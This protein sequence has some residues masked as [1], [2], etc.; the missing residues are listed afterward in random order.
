VSETIRVL[1]ADDHAIVR[2]GVS[3]LLDAEADIEVVAECTTGAEAVDAARR[4]RP[5]LVLMDIGM[6]G[7]NGIA[8]TRRIKERCPE[9][10]VLVLTVHRSDEYFFEMLEA[11]ASGYVLKAAE[12]DELI[13]AVRAIARG[14]VFLYPSM[15]GRLLQH[16]LDHVGADHQ[17]GP[18]TR[19]ERQVLKLIAQG[20]TTTEIAEKLVVSPSTVYSHRTNLMH[21][22]GLS[23]RHE[24]VR[25][26]RD[27]GLI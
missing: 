15:A 12:T 11:G 21:K 26:A 6:P 2:S 14:D 9:V 1:V 24:L 17:E 22:L 27:H 20:Y 18:L 16:Y 23:T 3:M 19:R 25:Y 4:L 10:N 8:A 5:N 13:Q 7:M